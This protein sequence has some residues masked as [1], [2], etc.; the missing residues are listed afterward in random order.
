MHDKIIY[1]TKKMG[2][3]RNRMKENL[4]RRKNIRLKYYD[5]S[6]EGMYFITICTRNRIKLF[7]EIETKE[8]KL[9]KVGKIVEK[10]IINLEKIYNN[11]TIDEY[12]V[13]PNHIHIIIIIN[14]KNNLTI[15]RIIN[16]YKGRITKTI[17]YPIWQKL[18][19]EHIIRNESEYYKIKQYIQNNIVNWKNDCNF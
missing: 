14:E 5:Y 10:S 4:P 1:N 11:I 19:Y 18:F 13:M 16:Q 9:T 15:S 7:G 3:E 2:A 8:I 12:I 6:E 17:G